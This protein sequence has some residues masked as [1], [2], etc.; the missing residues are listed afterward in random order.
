MDLR[1]GVLFLGHWFGLV[2][3]TLHA[4][5]DAVPQRISLAGIGAMGLQRLPIQPVTRKRGACLEL[6]GIGA[7]RTRSLFF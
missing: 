5:L 3:L 6:V 4:V 2:Y 1:I 7:F